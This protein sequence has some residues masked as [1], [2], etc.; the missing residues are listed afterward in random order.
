MFVRACKANTTAIKGKHTF[1]LGSR[2]PVS[3]SFD[4]KGDCQHSSTNLLQPKEMYSPPNRHKH[5]SFRCMLL[6]NEKPVYFAS[7]ALT[8]AQIGYV[9]IELESLAGVWAM[10][11][12]L[13]YASHFI[14]ETDHKPVEA[15]LSRSI[16]QATP[17][18]QRILFWTF[19]HYFTVH[20]IPGLTNQLADS[21]S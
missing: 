17:R 7:K 9:G 18:Q 8:G 21:L 20:Y 6:Q 4:E 3:I 15:I 11:K 14:L 1:Q 16:N 19:S 2:T 12:F 13:L 10:E 5:K